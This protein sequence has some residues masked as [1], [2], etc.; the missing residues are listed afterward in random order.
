MILL[1]IA[2]GLYSSGILAE[3][4]VASVVEAEVELEVADKAE[5]DVDAVPVMHC[6]CCCCC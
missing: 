6:C 1:V 5:E 4:F 2:F 3:S